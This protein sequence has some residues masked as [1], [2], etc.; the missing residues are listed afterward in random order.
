MLRPI[1]DE[2]EPPRELLL[3][4]LTPKKEDRAL[5]ALEDEGPKGLVEEYPGELL[6]EAVIGGTFCEPVPLPLWDPPPAEAL[7]EPPLEF[8]DPAAP[9][10]IGAAFEDAPFAPRD[11][12][13]EGEAGAPAAAEEDDAAFPMADE[14][15]ELPPFEG[16]ELL[17]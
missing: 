17:L 5:S 9:E 4:E 12:V 1:A 14:S 11:P 8:A 6:P 10:L 2:L 13:F 7:G 15:G 3:A 16:G